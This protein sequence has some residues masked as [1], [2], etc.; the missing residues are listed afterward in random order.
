MKRFVLAMVVVALLASGCAAKSQPTPSSSPS[1]TADP[2]VGMWRQVKDP[3]GASYPI[4]IRQTPNGYAGIITGAWVA[5]TSSKAMASPDAHLQTTLVRD[6]NTLSGR[7]TLKTGEVGVKLVYSPT[8]GQMTFANELDAGMFTP[9]VMM[10]KVSD[11]YAIPS[12]SPF[13]F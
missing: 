12:G 9:P 3:Y 2:F 4:V 7:V 13:P 6:G 5:A 11:D 1:T 8:T 10:K